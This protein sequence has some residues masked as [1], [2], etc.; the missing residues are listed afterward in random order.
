M[1]LSP[2]PFRTSTAVAQ[3]IT[4]LPDLGGRHLCSFMPL[5]WLHT[6]D[7]IASV[8][9]SYH[10]FLRSV[11]ANSERVQ[12]DLQK[13]CDSSCASHNCSRVG[14][15]G[16]RDWGSLDIFYQPS[17]LVSDENVRPP[18]RKADHLHDL[19]GLQEHNE[20]NYSPLEV[21]NNIWN[22]A[23]C[24]FLPV[25]FMMISRAF[26]DLDQTTAKKSGPSFDPFDPSWRRK[27]YLSYVES[28]P[29]LTDTGSCV[30]ACI[31]HAREQFRTLF[32]GQRIHA[33]YEWSRSDDGSSRT[34]SDLCK[35]CK[36]FVC[37]LS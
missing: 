13:E 27:K 8:L 2:Y 22:Q 34:P 21:N 23:R 31:I 28:L 9:L 32:L 24:F 16:C 25:N 33:P 36:D 30:P 10:T 26:N 17:S 3:V 14:S 1:R 12:Q 5:T 37:R 19:K 15:I 11:S 20:G 7:T 4:K 29:R 35:F 6:C 18:I